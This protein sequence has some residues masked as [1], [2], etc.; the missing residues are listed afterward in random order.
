M[1]ILMNLKS[2]A[3]VCGLAVG[4]AASTSVWAIPAATVGDVDNFI[5][6]TLLPNSDPVTQENWADLQGVGDLTFITRIGIG[7]P[8]EDSGLEGTWELV[9][10]TDDVYALFLEG[11]TPEYFL[12]KTGKNNN[13]PGDFRDFLYENIDSLG[14]AVIDLSE[15]GIDNIGKISHVTLFKGEGTVTVSEPASL[16]LLGIALAGLGASRRRRQ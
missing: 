1:E 10:G 13:Y 3:K 5:A 14:Y 7:E 6:S 4:L 9:D 11:Y 16:A 12:V 8:D 2:F 15:A